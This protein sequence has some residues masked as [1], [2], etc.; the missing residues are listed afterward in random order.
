MTPAPKQTKAKVRMTRL[1]KKSKGSAVQVFVS[2]DKGKAHLRDP[3]VLQ[4]RREDRRRHQDRQDEP[5]RPGLR[6]QEP[7]AK[8]K[9]VKATVID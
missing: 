6:A 2:S 8:A 4:E 9:T 1:M 7:P 3:A 5:L